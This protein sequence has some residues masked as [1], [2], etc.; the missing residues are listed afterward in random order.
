MRFGFRQQILTAVLLLSTS[1]ARADFRA[2]SAQSAYI[3]SETFRFS[4]SSGVLKRPGE[5]TLFS[6]PQFGVDYAV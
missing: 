2:L 6:F 3:P 1:I 4:I 5:E